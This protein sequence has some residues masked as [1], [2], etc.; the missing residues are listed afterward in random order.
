MKFPSHNSKN[1][2]IVSLL[3]AILIA[4]SIF[5]CLEEF[6]NLPQTKN[7]TN[8]SDTGNAD[9]QTRDVSEGVDDADAHVESTCNPGCKDTDYCFLGVCHTPPMLALG[10]SHSCALSSGVVQCWGNNTSGQT[11]TNDANETSVH[12]NPSLVVF[13]SA[14][15][16][17]L[18]D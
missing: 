16:S 8:V 9:T 10:A 13:E 2:S 17:I 1:R 12:F 15:L 5:G 4:T 14:E 18:D 11:G 7:D 3:S 6:D